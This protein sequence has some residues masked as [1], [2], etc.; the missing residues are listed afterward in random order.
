MKTQMI[1]TFV[2]LVAFCISDTLAACFNATRGPQWDTRWYLGPDNVGYTPDD[3]SLTVDNIILRSLYPA[4][5]PAPYGCDI[6]RYKIQWFSGSWSGYY[7][8]GSQ[9]LYHKAGENRR[10]WWACFNDHTHEFEYCN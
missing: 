1:C 4:N 7:Y 5:C 6:V 2:I 3:L 8:P 9:D 10:H